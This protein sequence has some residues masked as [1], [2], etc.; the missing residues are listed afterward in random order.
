MLLFNI[1][2]IIL[3]MI[4]MEYFISDPIPCFPIFKINEG[5]IKIFF[6]LAV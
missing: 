4:T 1:V 6:R 5:G 3:V 2:I